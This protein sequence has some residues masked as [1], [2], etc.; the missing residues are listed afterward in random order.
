[1]KVAIKNGLILSLATLLTFAGSAA[2]AP[3]A[4]G[5]NLLQNPGFEA[6]YVKQC[7]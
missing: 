3:A 5:P 6:P 4:D 2:A 1:M 7:C